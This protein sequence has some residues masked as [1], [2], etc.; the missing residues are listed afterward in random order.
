MNAWGVSVSIT[1]SATITCDTRAAAH[2]G[3]RLD[4]KRHG[5][6]VR[7]SGPSEGRNQATHSAKTPFTTRLVGGDG[8]EPPTLSV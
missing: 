7:R 6:G 5:A 4:A 8:L 3:Q 1:P 2:G